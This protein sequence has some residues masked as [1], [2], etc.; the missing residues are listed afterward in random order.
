MKG[1]HAMRKMLIG[2]VM[3][4]ALA[5]AAIAGFVWSTGREGPPE[6]PQV[7]FAALQDTSPKDP[8]NPARIFHIDLAKL[9][10]DVPLSPADRAKLTPENLKALSQEEIDQIYARLTA[11]PIPDGVLLGDLFFERGEDG[12]RTRLAEILNGGL[13]RTADRKVAALEKVGKSLWK[14]KRF[15]RAERMLRNAIEDFAA[16]K[17]LIEDESKIE[18]VEL[19]RRG[20]LSWISPRTTAWLLFPAK[21]YCGQSLLDGRRESIIIDYAYS[22]DLP[23]YMDKP[24]ALAGRGGLAIRDEIRMVRPGFYLGRAYANRIFLLNFTVYDPET[25]TNGLQDFLDGKAVAE[26]CW[27]GEQSAVAVQ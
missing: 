26:D 24:D 14:G 27:A 18:T 2:A 20:L 6:R 13:G 3:V 1:R 16:L 7:P 4:L 19:P 23:G 22:H 17:P 9:E 15:Y 8:D 25:M 11:G 5:A 21:L 10:H 12:L